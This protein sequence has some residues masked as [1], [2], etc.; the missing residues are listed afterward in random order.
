MLLP[1]P[2][3]REYN[4]AFMKKNFGKKFSTFVSIRFVIRLV[5]LLIFVLAGFFLYQT[6][7]GKRDRSLKIDQTA[8]VIQEVR[9]ISQLFTSVYYDELVLDTFKLQDKVPGER[10][11]EGMLALRPGVGTGAPMSLPFRRL[12]LV[13]IARGRVF[14]GYDFSKLDAA[15]LVIEGSSI[16]FRLPKVEVLEVVINP[17]D[18]E[19]FVEEGRWSLDEAVAL[20]Q[21]AGKMMTQRAIEK[22]LLEQA[23]TLAHGLLTNFFSTLGFE[24]ITIL[25]DQDE[26]PPQQ[27][28]SPS[29]SLEN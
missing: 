22:G 6:F 2:L 13:V 3:F 28:F 15:D 12:D 16:T 14:A 10:I 17:S 8:I 29:P 5:L 7:F 27:M 9:K 11:L 4:A 20:K 26:I 19:I 1:N 21:R 23:E 25:S 18:Y 24:Q